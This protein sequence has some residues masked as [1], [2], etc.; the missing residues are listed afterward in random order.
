MFSKSELASI[1]AEY[2]NI[3][4]ANAFQVTLQSKNTHHEWHI[5]NRENHLHGKVF[6]SCM[7]YHRHNRMVGFHPHGQATSLADAIRLIQEHDAY[8]L[9]KG[10]SDRGKGRKTNQ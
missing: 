3:L 6:N 10:G 9:N 2:F 7:V 4:S 1:D 5:L 8:Q